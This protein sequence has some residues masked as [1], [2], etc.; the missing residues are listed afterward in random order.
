M[1]LKGVDGIGEL[2]VTLAGYA[3]PKNLIDMSAANWPAVDIRV[4]APHGSG[5]SRV[6]CMRAWDA[7]SFADWLDAR[8]ARRPVDHRDMIFPE[9]N[10]QIQVAH[11][12]VGE[13]TANGPE[14]PA[15]S[16]RG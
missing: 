13:I 11:Q 15:A 7:V 14:S 1:Q 16:A 9:P 4:Q 3:F 5:T 10:L 2:R 6:A 12:T 8:G